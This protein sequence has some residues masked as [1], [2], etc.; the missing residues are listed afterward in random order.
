M[1]QISLRLIIPDEIVTSALV[2]KPLGREI[3]FI[4]FTVH[5]LSGHRLRRLTWIQIINVM[6]TF[7]SW[8][9][10]N[11]NIN[12]EKVSFMNSLRLTISRLNADVMLILMTLL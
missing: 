4:Y 9:N 7:P 1:G 12:L 6:T 5:R 10:G 3:F 8:G 11:Q 2:S